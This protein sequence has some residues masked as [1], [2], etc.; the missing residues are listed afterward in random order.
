M[1]LKFSWAP[2]EFE[3]T[4]KAAGVRLPPDVWKV[5]FKHNGCPSVG[6]TIYVAH[7]SAC[8]DTYEEWFSGLKVRAASRLAFRPLTPGGAMY[9][10]VTYDSW[11]AVVDGLA[12]LGAGLHA[13]RALIPKARDRTIVCAAPETPY[14]IP[15]D[16][17]GPA[18]YSLWHDHIILKDAATDHDRPH[19]HLS[20][21]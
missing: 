13:A 16:V 9:L 1:H 2:Q 19:L 17:P 4:W 20:S 6:P 8:L 7:S 21:P 11:V 14:A 15:A 3:C 12:S 18:S 10:P 5:T